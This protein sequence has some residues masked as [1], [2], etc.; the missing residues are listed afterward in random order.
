MDVGDVEILEY[1]LLE[2]GEKEW[3]IDDRRRGVAKNNFK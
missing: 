1:L 3:S 2:K